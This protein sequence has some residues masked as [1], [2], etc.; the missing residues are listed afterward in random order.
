M[1]LR[2]FRPQS[3]RGFAL[4][5]AFSVALVLL[6]LVASLY[7]IIV[8]RHALLRKRSEHA[9]NLY[10]TEAGINDAIARLRIGVN[11]PGIVPGTGRWYC[12]DVDAS[13]P[14]AT[15]IA[16]CTVACSPPNDVRVC[17]SNNVSGRNKI[18]VTANF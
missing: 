6:G 2:M 15:N 18:D 12:L 13:P 16:D 7:W 10:L 5:T 17:V 11:P 3:E 9:R 1:S 4:F 14:A 8:Q